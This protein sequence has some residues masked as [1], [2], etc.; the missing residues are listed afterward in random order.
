MRH[1]GFQPCGRSFPA[2]MHILLVFLDGIGLGEDD[3]STNPFASATTPT[4]WD[5]ANGHKW[6]ADTG[7]QSSARAEFIPTDAVLGVPGRP[8]S[9][10]NQATILTGINVPQRLGYH[11]GPKPD[12]A[13]RALLDET[14]IY[15][16]LITAGKSADL[17]NAFP[18]RLH[19]DINRGKTLRSSIQHAPHAAGLPMHTAEDLFAGD[20]M[21]EEWTGKAWREYL[22]YADAPLYLP[23][24]AGRKMVELSRRYDF[25]LFSHW[26]TDVI[27][28]R[29][30]LSDGLRLIE[31]F[32]GV[33]RGALDS[34]D[35]DEGLLIITSDHGNFEALDHGKHTENPVPTV[36]IGAQRQLFAEGYSDLTQITP[37]VLSLL[38][39]E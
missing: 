1:R 27:G 12:A 28:H 21:S 23:E 30:P 33:M 29:G 39:V 4:L 8:Q 34:W 10:T 36:V 7:R 13:T 35:D 9:G 22:G 6:L 2:N 25:A 37:R 38:G 24:Q 32:D 5:L 31:M 18:P 16:T 17:I 26:Y 15:K 11:Y 20:A 3:P 19:H 14:N